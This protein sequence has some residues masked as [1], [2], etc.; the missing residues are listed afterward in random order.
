MKTDDG[1]NLIIFIIIMKLKSTRSFD[2]LA[3][4]ALKTK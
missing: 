2:N 3:K 1:V 4:H